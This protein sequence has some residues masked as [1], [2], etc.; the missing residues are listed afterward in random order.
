MKNSI[1]ILPCLSDPTYR[2]PTLAAHTDIFG[3][4]YADIDYGGLE[5][6]SEVVYH[7]L[8]HIQNCG[9]NQEKL[10]LA[11]PRLVGL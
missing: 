11:R 8:A 10:Y 4:R 3:S 9:R 1:L 6:Y 7:P 2:G 5:V